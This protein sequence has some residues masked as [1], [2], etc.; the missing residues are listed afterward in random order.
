[1]DTTFR[2]GIVVAGVLAL[3]TA[4]AGLVERASTDPGRWALPLM[5]GAG[6][7][8]A[9]AALILIAWRRWRGLVALLGAGA[10]AIG[11]LAWGQYVGVIWALNERPSVGPTAP[12]SALGL[13][14]GGLSIVLL[15]GRS[16][17][18]RL[19]AAGSLGCAALILG[20]VAVIGHL[21]GLETAYGW[22]AYSTM[23]LSTACGLA[24]IG[25]GLVLASWREAYRQ[26][27]VFPGWLAPALGVA[28]AAGTVTLWWATLNEERDLLTR[29]TAVAHQ[30][31]SRRL[32]LWLRTRVNP[33]RRS[34]V[35]WSEPFPIDEPDWDEQTRLFLADIDELVAMQLFDLRAD[36]PR[37][38]HRSARE[39]ESLLKTNPSFAGDDSGGFPQATDRPRAAVWQSGDGSFLRIDVP[40]TRRN[41][42]LGVIR[43][44][45]R[46]DLLLAQALDGWAPDTGVEVRHGER[47]LYI[48]EH[49]AADADWAPYR[50]WATEGELE[51]HGVRLQIIARPA[52]AGRAQAEH[53]L[54]WAILLSGLA[55][56]LLV[57]ATMRMWMLAL[58]RGRLAAAS[59]QAAE[60]A[61]LE[62]QAAN[63]ELESFCYSVSHD[64]R[65][66][67]RGIA[68]FSEALLEDCADVLP[69][70]GKE[71]LQRIC[72]AA[73]RMAQLIDDLLKLSRMTRQDLNWE[74]VDISLI[75]REVVGR[76]RAAEPDRAV[77]IQIQPD[78]R[79]LGDRRLLTVAMENLLQ[80]GWK[81]TS[82]TSGARIE[83]AAHTEGD[84]RIVRVSDNGA[85]F[86]MAHADKLFGAFQRL[87]GMTEFPGTG[88]GLATVARV[89]HRHGGEIRAQAAVDRGAT[90]SFSV[91]SA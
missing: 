85:G 31:A 13:V 23:K 2:N 39:D 62:L 21:L 76:L 24:A 70:V 79:V 50:H 32:D 84:R 56:A 28:L 36:P 29:W 82:R 10:A 77:D 47:Q 27:G 46:A 1:M 41:E 64:L 57:P 52:R 73:A 49:I 86:D 12:N 71:H 26:T 89:I 67:L 17:T 60:R 3:S 63:R 33:L 4:A 38:V 81:F 11:L 5:T 53:S 80:N 66:P 58:E 88:I 7:M 69:S 51:L 68:G 19:M 40:I 74:H 37:L 6:L 22:G 83:V 43:G 59:A 16:G 78:I 48:H 87:H 30:E 91:P 35:R 75:A 45:F 15:A 54:A 34:A 61:N 42:V 9:G 44:I 14:M 65:T 90:F 20:Q 18:G 55:M 8:L 25:L 72:A